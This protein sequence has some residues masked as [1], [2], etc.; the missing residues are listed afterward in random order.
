VGQQVEKSC[1]EW[2]WKEATVS[3]VA[4]VVLGDGETFSTAEGC[5]I[6]IITKDQLEEVSEGFEKISDITPILEIGLS[7]YR[8]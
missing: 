6:V 3:T 5:S 4:V 2:Q 8:F 1:Q 7:E